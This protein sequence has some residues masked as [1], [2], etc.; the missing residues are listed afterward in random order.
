MAQTFKINDLFWTFQGEGRYSGHRALFIRLPYCNYDCPWCDTEFNSYKD[1]PLDDFL[2]FI[3][4]EEARFAVITGGEPLANKQ[5]PSILK[6]LKEYNFYIACETNGSFPAPIEIDFVTTSPKK[7]TK[8]KLPEYYVDPSTFERTCEW[9]YVV[10]ET[11]NFEVLKRHYNYNKDVVY[12]L[13]P[14]F[15]Q[16]DQNLVRIMDFIQKNPQWKISLQTHKW[17][18]IP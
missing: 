4:L 1:W 3:N 6:V 7:Y 13:S 14:E 18:N 5:L 12:S 8:G 10:D 11:F 16:M 15:S 9:K 2:Q 17:I